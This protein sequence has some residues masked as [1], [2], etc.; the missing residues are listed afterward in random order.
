MPRIVLH[1][2]V[3]PISGYRLV[4]RHLSSGNQPQDHFCGNWLGKRGDIVERFL[5]GGDAR[6][7]ISVNRGPGEFAVL[8]VGNCDTWHVI[9]CKPR[10]DTSIQPLLELRPLRH[11]GSILSKTSRNHQGC[12]DKSQPEAHAG[13][14]G[15]RDLLPVLGTHRVRLRFQQR[16]AQIVIVGNLSELCPPALLLLLGAHD[17]LDLAFMLHR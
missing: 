13:S 15:P 8:D 16:L 1:V 2:G 9:L 6:A 7:L 14:S 4:Q 5:R 11:F 12:A 3:N 17:P 10:R